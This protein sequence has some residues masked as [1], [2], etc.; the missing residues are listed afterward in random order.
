MTTARQ[1]ADARKRLAREGYKPCHDH[2][3]DVNDI[4]YSKVQRADIL[5]PGGYRDAW[6]RDREQAANKLAL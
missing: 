6:V 2:D 5:L 4:D 1:I 3:I